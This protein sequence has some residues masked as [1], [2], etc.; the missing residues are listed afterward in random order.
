MSNFNEDMTPNSDQDSQQ[1]PNL[2]DQN[3]EV[4]D[5]DVTELS[6]QDKQKG[7]YHINAVDEVTQFEIICSVEKISELYLIP[8]LESILGLFPFK[9]KGFHSDNGSEYINHRVAELLNK[10]HKCPNQK[11]ILDYR[12]LKP[13][14]MRLK[15][16]SLRTSRLC[17]I[18]GD[19]LLKKMSLWV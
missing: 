7:V 12:L 11:L 15:Y 17:W 13:F 4:N 6:D 16:V 14:S 9:I 18:I 1:P 2:P 3:G 19:N 10:L 5:T 8:I